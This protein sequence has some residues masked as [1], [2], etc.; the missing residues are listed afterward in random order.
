MSPDY[1]SLL[2]AIER[3]RRVLFHLEEQAAGYT[4][5]TLPTELKIKLEDK[6]SEITELER[7]L[8]LTKPPRIFINYKRDASPD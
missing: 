7:R 6:K 5:L 1:Q 8:S 4:S 3:A 2:T